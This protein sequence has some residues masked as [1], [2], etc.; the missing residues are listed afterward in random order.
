MGRRD[1]AILG[2]FFSSGLRIAELCSLN[3]DQFR[4]DHLGT[5]EI[6][7]LSVIGKGRHSRII[8]INREAQ[9]LIKRYLADRDDEDKALFIHFRQGKKLEP[10]VVEPKRLTPR[11]IQ[12]L[13]RRYAIKAGIPEKLTPHSLRHGFAVDLLR[14]GADLRTV[15]GSPRPPNGDD[16]PDLHPA[17]QPYPS[18]GLPEAGVPQTERAGYRTTGTT[19]WHPV[20]H[21]LRSSPLARQNQDNPGRH[22]VAH[23]RLC[24]PPP[25]RS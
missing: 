6:L 24:T 14:G 9:E 16:D 17:H 20:C 5:D 4:E 7:E 15:Q 3:R 13:V 25:T 8:F 23:P 11:A 10:E 19:P 12:Q 18:R 1:R 2:L 22:P 21:R